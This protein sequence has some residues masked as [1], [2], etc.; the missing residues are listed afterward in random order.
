M[1]L[2]YIDVDDFKYVIDTLGHAAGDVVAAHRPSRLEA[3]VRKADTVA[4]LGG[5]EFVVILEG[6]PWRDGRRRGR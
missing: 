1:A 3:C 2:L 4:R 6:G 5:D